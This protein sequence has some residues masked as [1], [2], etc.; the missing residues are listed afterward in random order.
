[1]TESPQQRVALDVPPGFTGLPISAAQESG[2][3]ATAELAGQIS[4]QT[5][6]EPGEL[7]E[8]LADLAT[9]LANINIE[10]YGKFAVGDDSPSL[11]SLTLARV[12]LSEERAVRFSVNRQL[13]VDALVHQYGERKPHA[14]V[15]R[16]SLP[17]GP[18]LAAVI[19]GQ[20]ELPPEVA[21][22]PE[23][24]VHPVFRTEFQIPTPDGRELLLLNVNAD[25]DSDWSTI[26][27][28]SVAVAQSLRVE[29]VEQ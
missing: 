22:T 18:A 24:L 15:R 7:A 13:L 27:E 29:Q 3:D 10:I 23:G 9:G 12:P 16:I 26:A 4:Q 11:A 21:G 5:N 28:Q 8:L 2:S 1:M 17:I 6:Q 14:D 25:S 19:T 20:Y